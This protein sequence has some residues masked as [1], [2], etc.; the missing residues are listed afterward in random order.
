MKLK[1][2]LVA[3]LA[4]NANFSRTSAEVCLSDL[5]DKVGDVKNGSQVQEVGC[6]TN[7]TIDNL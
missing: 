7:A 1:V 5:V 4:Q 3:F 2:Q 6:R